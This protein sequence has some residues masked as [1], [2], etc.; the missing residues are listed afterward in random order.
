MGLGNWIKGKAKQ[1]GQTRR[2]TVEDTDTA[3]MGVGSATPN[4]NEELD[5][6]KREEKQYWRRVAEEKAKAGLPRGSSPRKSPAELE[7]EAQILYDESMSRLGRES[8]FQNTRWGTK[9][10]SR[11]T[12]EGR[13]T[14]EELLLRQQ[15][16]EAGTPKETIEYQSFY[17][18][19]TKSIPGRQAQ[20]EWTEI[21]TGPDGKPVID[22][23]TGKPRTIFHPRVEGT[24]DIP[25]MP[26]H[27]EFVAKPGVP[28]S[29]AQRQLALLS[30][31]TEIIDQKNALAEARSEQFARS[32]TG[33]VLGAIGTGARGAASATASIPVGMKR[34]IES[35]PQADSRLFVGSVPR[36]GNMRTPASNA[37]IATKKMP[38][39][40]LL[41][42]SGNRAGALLGQTGKNMPYPQINE[43]GLKAG[44]FM[45]KVKMQVPRLNLD[46]P[47][48]RT[49][50]GVSRTQ[51]KT[52]G[53][54]NN[55][56]KAEVSRIKKMRLNI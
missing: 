13:Q 8:K 45:P 18:P 55:R 10:P 35:N 44:L 50:I 56:Y 39:A 7:V 26:G 22:S 24:P 46:Q 1:A 42:Q 15:M 28:L 17:V 21:V 32:R 52:K 2:Q 41:G 25:Y 12:R 4:A 36:P 40:Q 6:A 19:P 47:Q 31:Q 5:K 37:I 20:A 11:W 48:F 49:G 9:P 3:S 16:E 14:R 53:Q 29:P 54:G 30:G 33:H 51:G 27:H 43:Q 23:A 38:A 34:A